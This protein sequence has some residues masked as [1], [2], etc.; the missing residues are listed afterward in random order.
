MLVRQPPL[1]GAT[2]DYADE[3]YAPKLGSAVDIHVIQKRALN[4]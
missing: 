3:L 4:R 2:A 1:V